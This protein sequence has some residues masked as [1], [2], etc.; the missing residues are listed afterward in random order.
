MFENLKIASRDLTNPYFSL[1]PSCVS[2]RIAMLDTGAFPESA[3]HSP[4]GTSS[5]ESPP[6][7]SPVELAVVVPT[8]HE[9]ENIPVLMPALEKALLA[10][11]WELIFVDDNSPDGTTDPQVGAVSKKQANASPHACGQTGR[12]RRR[13]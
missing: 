8:F 12:E 6:L 1:S 10:I 2:L 11:P 5:S 7:T 3:D 4:E 13:Y 9:P